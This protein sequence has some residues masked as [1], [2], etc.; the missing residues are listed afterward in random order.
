VLRI[1][2]PLK[3]HR[4]RPGL[5]LRTLGSVASTLTN[6]FMLLLDYQRF[7]PQTVTLKKFG[8]LSFEHL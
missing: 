3:T 7:S 1:L 8:N 2:S 4:P 6:G 5:N